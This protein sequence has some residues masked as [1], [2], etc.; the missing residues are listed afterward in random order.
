LKSLDQF[1]E[2][3]PSRIGKRILL[4]T[5]NYQKDEVVTYLLM[6]YMRYLKIPI[7]CNKYAV[8]HK[9]NL[10][11]PNFLLIFATANTKPE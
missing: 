11:N 10:P 2:K 4:Y 6:Y 3:Y 9:K 7:L 1:C 8:L 5:K